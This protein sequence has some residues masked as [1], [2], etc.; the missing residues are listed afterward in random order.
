VYVS[1]AFC[2]REIERRRLHPD[3]YRELSCGGD[4]EIGMVFYLDVVVNA[5]EQ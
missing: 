1:I 2:G 3:R 4:T 5:I